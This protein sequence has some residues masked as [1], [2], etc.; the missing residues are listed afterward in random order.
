MNQEIQVTESQLFILAAE[1]VMENLPLTDTSFNPKNKDECVDL[2]MKF[3]D[4]KKLNLTWIQTVASANISN[5]H[6][7]V[8]YHDEKW[9]CLHGMSRATNTRD[10]FLNKI[11]GISENVMAGKVSFK[12]QFGK[13]F[14]KGG[15]K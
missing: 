2:L 10:E 6:C 9:N 8:D 5:R 4:E 14:F 11:K 3:V 12:D 1:M 15:K 13:R 7:F